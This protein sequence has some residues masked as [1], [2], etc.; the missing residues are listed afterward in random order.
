MLVKLKN[1]WFDPSGRYLKATKGPHEVPESWKDKLPAS[2]EVVEAKK[3]S[4]PAPPKKDDL[5][6]MKADELRKLAGERGVKVETT[7]TI[8]QMADK[9]TA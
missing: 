8:A 2:A 3:E 4:K 7:D 6:K 1:N 9:L 5:L